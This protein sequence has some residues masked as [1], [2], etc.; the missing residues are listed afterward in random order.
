ME[1]TISLRELAATLKK[2]FK[3]I[4]LVAFATALASGIISYFVLS[5]VYQASTQLLV[6]QAKSEQQLYNPAEVQTNLQL[7]NTYNVIIKSPAILEKVVQN[8]DLDMT[9][10]E[11]NGKI[12]VQNEKDSQ[13]VNVA[14]QDEDPAIAADIANETARVFQS[15]IVKIMN[16]DNVSILAKAEANGKAAP[17]K[18][19]PVLNIVIALVVGLMGGIALA[20]LL[21]Y[22]DNTV[23]NEQD[24]EK[25]LDLPV[26]GSVTIIDEASK[27]KSP[28]YAG[29]KAVVR[30]ETI[31]S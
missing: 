13:V 27:G 20:F 3:L 25:L 26:L 17:V 21:E 30:S 18:P 4:L 24:V 15:E 6:N 28:G 23:K 1:E 14:V 9:A 29:K 12:N 2:R 8:L 5:P 16:V 7:I 22:M 10:A 19:K 11:V 31:G